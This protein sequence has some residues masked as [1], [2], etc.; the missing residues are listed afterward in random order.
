[1]PASLCELLAR[2]WLSGNAAANEVFIGSFYAVDQDGDIE[3]ARQL[4]SSA[5]SGS[6]EV[7][8]MVELL[9]PEL[10]RQ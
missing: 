2:R 10:N 6:A 3:R 1:M 9:M 8:T 5:R 7:R 4:L